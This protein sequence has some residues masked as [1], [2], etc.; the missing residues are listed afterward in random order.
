MLARAV[1]YTLNKKARSKGFGISR[2]LVIVND[3]KEGK[4]LRRLVNSPELGYNIFGYIAL[5]GL[6]EKLE[7]SF[8]IEDLSNI[9]N[10][11]RIDTI[12][13]YDEK[14]DGFA[15]LNNELLRNGL[16]NLSEICEEKNIK[17]K[18]VSPETESILRFAYIRDIGGI[19]LYIP[20]RKKI[21][22]LRNFTK[23]AFDLLAT[24][25]LM[26]LLSPLYILTVIAIMIED[27]LPVLY[28]QKRALIS[29]K[30]E[31]DFYKFRSMIKGAE[32]MQAELYN[33][34]KT[35]GG[36]FLLED[37]PRITKVGKI[38]RRFSIDELPQLMN[39][40]KG[41]MSLVG[42][43]P[44][45]LSDLN[46]I[47]PENRLGGFYKLRAN[48]KPGVT[49]LWQIS[50]RRTVSFKEMVLLDLYYIENQSFALD[51]E[52]LFETIPVVLFG[53]GAY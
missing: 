24:P 48:A 38:I 6:P 45:S 51:L 16:S 29:G 7:P 32:N 12:I 27:G 17:L 1:L 31:F 23:R 28:K 40:I 14:I 22:R 2:C 13:I 20:S 53:R 19:P 41:E 26:I 46:N 30:G 15:S 21:T 37:D 3:L 49:G 5:N 44:L 39:V 8:K 25:L 42:P 9:V 34:N 35:S 11:D 10:K 18:L 47:A 4:F 52:I 36:L 33:R 50:G 43:R